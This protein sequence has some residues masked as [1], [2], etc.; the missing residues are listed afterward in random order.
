[1]SLKSKI[2]FKKWNATKEG[3]LFLLTEKEVQDLL[4]EAGITWEQWSFKGYHLSR[5]NDSGNYELGNCRFLFWLEN[6]REKKISEKMRQHSIRQ[7]AKARTYKD[8]A[9][10]SDI[11]IR[12]NKTKLAK[13]IPI[14]RKCMPG[15]LCGRHKNGGWNKGIPG[16][17]R[18]HEVGGPG[19][20][21]GI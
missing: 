15:C 14:S 6:W 4:I 10:F 21:S 18:K 13:G 11:V 17:T 7:I 16:S 19:K 2:Q 3:I 1:M 8:P 12:G 9:K 5:Y 20:S